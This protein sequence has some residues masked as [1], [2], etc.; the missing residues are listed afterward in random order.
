[1]PQSNFG[2]VFVATVYK[3][4]ARIGTELSLKFCETQAQIRS[5]VQLWTLTTDTI[6]RFNHLNTA[7][8]T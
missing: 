8:L 7:L 4:K 1:M 2:D 6:N 3:A 5:D